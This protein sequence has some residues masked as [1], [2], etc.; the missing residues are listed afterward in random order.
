M[1]TI[2]WRC[3]AGNLVL[4]SAFHGVGH[5]QENGNTFDLDEGR[6]CAI[7]P[8]IG[9]TRVRW[10]ITGGA[11]LITMPVFH[12]YLNGK[13]V[14]AA[15]VGQLGVVTALVS[16]VRRKGEH[17]RSGKPDSVEEELELNVGGLIP[18]TEEHVRWLDR[19]LN[20]GDKVSIRV[21]ADGRIDRPRSRKRF[22]RTKDLRAQKRYVVEM[23]KKFGW[24]IKTR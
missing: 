15:G 6:V 13:K 14:S 23:A 5:N 21:A 22:N 4:V 19:N 2:G 9:L 24:K 11:A 18:T 3:W 1:A 12:V 8:D 17:T 7:L 16:W 20:V 10:R